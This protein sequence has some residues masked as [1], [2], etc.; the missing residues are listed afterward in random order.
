[1]AAPTG[2]PLLGVLLHELRCDGEQPSEMAVWLV[3]QN[4]PGGFP[5]LHCFGATPLAGEINYKSPLRTELMGQSSTI[6]VGAALAEKWNG[7]PSAQ[8]APKEPSCL[9]YSVAVQGP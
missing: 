4:L 6:T 3:W 8:G 5:L 9:S 2:H 1:M 7:S